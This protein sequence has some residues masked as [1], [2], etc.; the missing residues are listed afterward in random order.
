MIKLQKISIDGGQKNKE[1]ISMENKVTIDDG[2]K[3]VVNSN[4]DLG[5]IETVEVLKNS[6]EELFIADLFECVFSDKRDLE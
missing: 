5:D 6:L 4:R 1:I 3:A 2:E